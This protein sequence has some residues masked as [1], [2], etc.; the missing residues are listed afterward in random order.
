MLQK[1]KPVHKILAGMVL[2]VLLSGFIFLDFSRVFMEP[3]ELR[4]Q[5]YRFLL[6]GPQDYDNSP[7]ILALVDEL[8][9]DQYGVIL[10]TPRK[11]L[12]ELIQDLHE[13]QVAGIGID[14]I[15]DRP[16]TGP[17]TQE[18]WRTLLQEGDNAL[19][20]A[21]AVAGKQVVLAQI[22]VHD[23]HSTE[24]GRAGM[25]SILPVFA[26]HAQAGIT[27][28]RQSA[29]GVVRWI[30]LGG[31]GETPAFSDQLYRLYTGHPVPQTFLH[32]G[33]LTL[34][35]AGTPSRLDQEQNPFP[36]FS[37]IDIFDLPADYLQGKIVIIGSGIEYLGDTFQT[38]F[39]TRF[40]GYLSTFGAELHVLAF[41][42]ILNDRYLYEFSTNT[43]FWIMTVF[44]FFSSVLFLLASPILEVIALIVL[45][46][47]WLWLS[48][49]L[50][51]QQV[52]LPVAF[53]VLNLGVLFV[54]CQ[55]I[56]YFSEIQQTRFLQSTF[57]RYLS[58][59]VVDQLMASPEQIQLSGETR[60]L[61]AL[62]SDLQGFTSFSEKMTPLE[63]VE[64]LNEY[65]GEM[66]RIVFE[67]KGTLD[68]YMGDAV[69]AIYGAP[70]H[71]EDHAVKA[72]RTALMMQVQ[73]KKLRDRWQLS[74]GFELRV[75][76]GI[77]TGDMVV[78]NIG[79]M[80]H[81]DYTVIGDAVNLASRLEGVNKMFGT[82]V[83]MSD[84]TFKHTAGQFVTRELGRI[85]VKGK[86]LPVT[87]YELIGEASKA[88]EL[89]GRIE[90]A[91][92]YEKSL[93]QFYLR[94][95]EQAR[96]GFQ[97]LLDTNHDLAS[98]LLLKQIEKL[99]ETPPADSWQGEIVFSTK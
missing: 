75:R 38:P 28:V 17:D 13:K 99:I 30:N 31:S 80:E 79:S 55:L 23:D 29:D 10:P 54:A 66:T 93:Q 90:M 21:L 43:F 44:L 37:A 69:M 6:R 84:A 65:L 92:L 86:T 48:V 73:A 59:S 45:S 25:G 61:S 36:V 8:T 97:Q 72:C 40:N 49:L 81:Y 15:L 60:E 42:M 26:Q 32:Q 56:R 46:G 35:F 1:L 57:K 14:F 24:F 85:V 87:I 74:Q 94:Q 11:L 18:A 51:N 98:K 34:N 41:N 91:K 2:S 50:F 77:N 33:L 22:P 96:A 9:T 88:T 83:I 4:S 27:E 7:V 67:Q 78:G 89:T 12:A 52:I 95:F 64:K 39:S 82:D 3:M 5:D 71:F 53:P 19:E 68:K 76:I 58:P 20:Q 70:L 63:L 16:A 62:F 47:G